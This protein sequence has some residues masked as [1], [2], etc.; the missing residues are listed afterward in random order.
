MVSI[1][2]ALV[3]ETLVLQ[4]YTY[5]HYT[6]RKIPVV[7]VLIIKACEAI[8]LLHDRLKREFLSF[9]VSLTAVGHKNALQSFVARSFSK[10][11]CVPH[12]ILHLVVYVTRFAK[13]RHNSAFLKIQF[14]VLLCSRH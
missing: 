14:I 1:K 12:V 13:T 2:T 4:D 6:Q 7:M 3:R 11:H 9:S 5:Y 8:R 10:L